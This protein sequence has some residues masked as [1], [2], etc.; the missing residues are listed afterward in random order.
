MQAV[1][2][3]N[4]SDYK[5]DITSDH[6]LGLTSW[7]DLSSCKEWTIEL[8]IKNLFRVA[9]DLFQAFTVICFQ[10]DHVDLKIS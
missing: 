8:N 2:A 5:Q 1:R 7:L 6:C 9:K 4:C 10:L 3:V